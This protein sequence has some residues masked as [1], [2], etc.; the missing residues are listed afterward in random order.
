MTTINAA[1]LSLTT[2]TSTNSNQQTDSGFDTLLQSISSND[3]QAKKSQQSADST[4]QLM[5][6]MQQ[7]MFS[8]ESFLLGIGSDNSSGSNVTAASATSAAS[9]PFASDNGDGFITGDGPLP[10]FLAYVDKAYNLTPD[11]QK[12]L[13]DI[14]LQFRDA[15]KTPETLAA[16][17]DALTKAGIGAPAVS[18]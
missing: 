5:G 7:I 2:L 10:K 17:S 1:Y 13:R 11:Q 16:I 12:S 6:F 15:Q 4:D 14:A 9:N 3:C 8:T 18:A